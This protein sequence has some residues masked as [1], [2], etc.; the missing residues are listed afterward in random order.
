VNPYIVAPHP[1]HDGKETDQITLP[2]RGLADSE[3]ID[4]AREIYRRLQ[5]T[6]HWSSENEALLREWRMVCDEMN[7]RELTDSVTGAAPDGHYGNEGLEDSET[8]EQ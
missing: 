6:T 3:V 8:R 7:I 4:A 2:Y 5:E 1:E